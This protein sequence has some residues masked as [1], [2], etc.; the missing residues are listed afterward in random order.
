MPF[1]SV[2]D[3]SYSN[4]PFIAEFRQNLHRPTYLHLWECLLQESNT[5]IRLLMDDRSATSSPV[6][7]VQY[8]CSH[9]H[10]TY[11]PSDYHPQLNC[12]WWKWPALPPSDLVTLPYIVV[13]QQYSHKQLLYPTLV[14]LPQ[15]E[16][17]VVHIHTLSWFCHCFCTYMLCNREHFV[18]LV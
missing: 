8:C 16:P 10:I 2:I 5:N 6:K 12:I 14:L 7:E 11:E 4:V 3:C 17:W 18:S 13:A 1:H 15:T 9:L